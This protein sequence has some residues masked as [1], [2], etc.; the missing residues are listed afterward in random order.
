MVPKRNVILPAMKPSVFIALFFV[1]SLV[2]GAGCTA[3]IPDKQSSEADSTPPEPLQAGF[4]MA[5]SQGYAPLQVQF[6]DTSVSGDSPVAKWQWSFGDG[7]SSAQQHPKHIFFRPGQYQVTL[8]TRDSG[9]NGRDAITQRVDVWYPETEGLSEASGI[10]GPEG[11]RIELPDGAS[12]ELP[13]GALDR[14][15]EIT[16]SIYQDPAYPE[17]SRYIRLAP[18]NLAL[19]RPAKVTLP[20]AEDKDEPFYTVADLSQEPPSKQGEFLTAAV[21]GTAGLGVIVFFT[22]FFRLFAMVHAEPIYIVPYLPGKY[23]EPA[24]MIFSL[25]QKTDNGVRELSWIPGHSALYLGSREEKFDI[26]GGGYVNNGYTIIESVPS[27]IYIR[28]WFD[29]WKPTGFAMISYHLYMGARRYDGEITGSDRQIVCEYAVAHKDALWGYVEQGNFTEDRFSCVGLLEASYD[30]AGK[31]NI[32]W[33]YELPLIMPKDMYD[34]TVAID[35]VTSPLGEEVAF[36]VYGTLMDRQSLFHSH[37]RRIEASVDGMVEG[38]SFE[39]NTFRFQPSEA[40]DYTI[41]LSCEGAFEGRV[42]EASMPFYIHILP[43]K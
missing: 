39:D 10:L 26:E 6:T 16:L 37:Y 9:G 33:W 20:I 36:P 24:D 35:E 21:E 41:T 5:P 31:S 13:A 17:S 40:G 42:Y 43:E 30:A 1:A 8:R 14:D 34:R 12:V 38:M 15:T 7:H 2:L 22:T 4:R 29:M 27:G 11:G 18:E 32:P 23:L 19:K 25:A 28:D 3:P